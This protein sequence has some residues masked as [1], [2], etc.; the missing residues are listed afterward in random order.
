[1]AGTQPRRVT[2]GELVAEELDAE[3]NRMPP[4]YKDLAHTLRRSAA[5]MRR[6]GSK[7]LVRVWE[8][9]D[10]QTQRRTAIR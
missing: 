1:M 3:A 10:R 9:P 4:S 6:E 5:F 8:D 2:V 7:K